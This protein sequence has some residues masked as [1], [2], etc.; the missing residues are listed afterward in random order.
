MSQRGVVIAF[1][2]FPVAGRV[3]TRLAAG[4]GA[5][6]AA[7]L[8]RVCSEEVFQ[9]LSRFDLRLWLFGRCALQAALLDIQG[10]ILESVA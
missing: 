9:Q 2:R 3:K 1:C 5:V 8:Y 6:T 7:Q 4:L 10:L